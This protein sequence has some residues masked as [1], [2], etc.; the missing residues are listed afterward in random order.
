MRCPKC[1]SETLLEQTIDDVKVDR[2]SSCQGT[3]FDAHELSLLLAADAR[4]GIGSKT[5]P[6]Q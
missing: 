2:C 1:R 6:R 3:W 5:R 4:P